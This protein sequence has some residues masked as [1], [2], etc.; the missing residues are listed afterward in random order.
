[1][2][3]STHPGSTDLSNYK[4]S[5][6]Y[7]YYESAWLQPLYFHEV[8]GSKHCTFKEEY[9]QSQRKS[10]INHELWIIMERSSKIRSCHC[11]CMAGMGQSCNH[12]AAAMYRIEAAVR[13]GLTSPFYTS[14]TS[15]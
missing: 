15:Q 11:T 9:K 1:M 12:V 5:K 3:Y 6:D 7:P 4:N 14:T 8:S 13:N 2:L 10:K